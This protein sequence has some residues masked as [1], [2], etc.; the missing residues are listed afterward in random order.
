MLNT[1]GPQACSIIL[2]I[3]LLPMGLVKKMQD[4][5]RAP[6]LPEPILTGINSALRI[7]KEAVLMLAPPPRQPDG[8]NRRKYFIGI[9]NNNME[10]TFVDE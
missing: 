1:T 2:I 9:Y 5:I 7:Q 3:F 10:I 8:A 4:R 6:F